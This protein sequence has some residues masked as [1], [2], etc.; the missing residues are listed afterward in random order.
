[1]R[2]GCIRREATV[3]EELMVERIQQLAVRWRGEAY[4]LA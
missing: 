1:M 2:Y 3:A 4:A